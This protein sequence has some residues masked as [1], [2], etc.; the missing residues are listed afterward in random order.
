M[1]P[2]WLETSERQWCATERRWFDPHTCRGAC[3]GCRRQLIAEQDAH[4][5]AEQGA[6]P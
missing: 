4:D 6:T 3:L 5:W 1:T 2:R